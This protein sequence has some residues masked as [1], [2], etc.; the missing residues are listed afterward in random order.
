MPAMPI[1]QTIDNDRTESVRI[2]AAA[3]ARCSLF[4]VGFVV[5]PA[6]RELQLDTVSARMMMNR[7]Q[8]SAEA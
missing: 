7:I 5:D 2:R 6:R 3:D 4:L 8:A 1:A